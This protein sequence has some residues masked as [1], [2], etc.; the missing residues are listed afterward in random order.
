VALFQENEKQNITIILL[1]PRGLFERRLTYGGH[2]GNARRWAANMALDGL[3][4]SA[5]ENG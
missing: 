1:T 3:R 2:P 4:R 5:Q